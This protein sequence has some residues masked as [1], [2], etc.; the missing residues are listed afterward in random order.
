MFLSQSTHT[1]LCPSTHYYSHFSD[2]LKVRLL[3]L[4]CYLHFFIEKREWQVFHLLVQSPGTQKQGRP[5]QAGGRR[6]NDSFHIVAG[7]R[8]F[9]CECAA[10]WKPGSRDLTQACRYWV[11]VSG[12]APLFILTAVYMVNHLFNAAP[13]VLNVNMSFE[14]IKGNMS[15]ADLF[16]L[17]ACCSPCRSDQVFSLVWEQSLPPVMFREVFLPHGDRGADAHWGQNS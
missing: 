3:P 2:K 11:W 9:R 7:L 14:G 4:I 13:P 15:Y 8:A 16:P 5:G 6:P 1:E 17:G 12:E 10:Q